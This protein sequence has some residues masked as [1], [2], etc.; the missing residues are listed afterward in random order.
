[1]RTVMRA[2]IGAMIGVLGGVDLIVFT[3]GIGEH[4]DDSCR[5]DRRS[6]RGRRAA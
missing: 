4:G 6:S 3:G 1:M 5:R 2:E